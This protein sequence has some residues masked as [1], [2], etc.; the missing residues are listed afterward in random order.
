MNESETRAEQIDPALKA[1][2]WGV[3]EGSRIRREFSITTGRIQSDIL[4]QDILPEL[5]EL[6]YDTIADA[7]KR[8]GGIPVIRKLFVE[9][10]RFLYERRAA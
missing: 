10:Q 4:G 7:A 1:A 6:K 2:G 5:L 9:F 3:V 8:L